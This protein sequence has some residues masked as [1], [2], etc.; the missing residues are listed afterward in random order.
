MTDTAY[1]RERRRDLPG[2]NDQSTFV[3]TRPPTGSE[4]HE[5]GNAIVALQ[6]CLR[7]LDGKQRTDEL[8]RVV[9]KGLKACKQ[10]V[11]A[12]RR[13]HETVGAPKGIHPI[14]DIQVRARGHEMRAAEYRVLADQ[15]RDPTARA[16]YRHL[17]ESYEAMWRRSHRTEK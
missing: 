14:N 13:V 6:F 2:S 8:Q 10:G 3:C 1:S 16:S 17:A 12:F 9:R 4:M 5:L 11:A 15:T 7:Q